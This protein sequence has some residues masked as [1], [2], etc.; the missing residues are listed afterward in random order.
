M[1]YLPNKIRNDE[2]LYNPVDNSHGP[3]LDHHR[4]GGFIGKKVCDTAPQTGG[5]GSLAEH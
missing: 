5:H 2:Q 3:A 1:E 4:L